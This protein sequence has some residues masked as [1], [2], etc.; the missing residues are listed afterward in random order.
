MIV[1]FTFLCLFEMLISDSSETKN[2]TLEEIELV[3]NSGAGNQ[4]SRVF[5]HSQRD[6]DGNREH[7]SASSGS[8]RKQSPRMGE[9]LLWE[10]RMWRRMVSRRA[11]SSCRMPANTNSSSRG[12]LNM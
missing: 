3:F 5:Q 6:G 7:L 9:D 10:R 2:G 12:S 11:M 4:A 8:S 1:L